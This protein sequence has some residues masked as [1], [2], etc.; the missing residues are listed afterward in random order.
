MARESARIP[1]EFVPLDVNYAHDRAVRQAGPMPELLFV[2]GL[3]YARKYKTDGL[4]PDYD[5]AIA[6]VGIPNVTRHA[7]TLVRADLWIATDDGWLIRSFAKWNPVSE[8]DRS[9]KQSKGGSLGNHNRWHTN[10]R[11]SDDCPFCTPIGKR[12]GTDRPTESLRIAEREGEREREESDHP[13]MHSSSPSVPSETG[14]A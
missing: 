8:A 5:L 11:R 1:G 12:L 9:G 10:G 14:V 7:A 6:G 13:S 4:I 2:R 3:A